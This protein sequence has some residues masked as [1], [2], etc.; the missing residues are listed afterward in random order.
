VGEFFGLDAAALA[1]LSG[2]MDQILAM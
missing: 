1:K 2:A